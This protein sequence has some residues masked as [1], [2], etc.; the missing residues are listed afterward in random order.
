MAEIQLPVKF[1]DD[2]I[3]VKLAREL[4]MGIHSLDTILQNNQ[5]D[6][7]NWE[8]IQKHPRFLQ[9]L[10]VESSTW[11]SALNTHER[12]KLK[13]AAMIEEWL[14]EL[15][16]RMHDSNEALN[17]KIEAGKLVRDL[18][19]FAKGAVGFEGGGERFSV[20]IN[21]GA[22]N[23]IKIEKDVTPKVIEAE[24]R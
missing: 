11:G 8:S 22:D 13:S 12:V 21:L 4:A 9:L 1:D 2:V 3:F 5:I 20:T 18:A 23:Q 14:P 10:E 19:G 6:Q 24:D 16:V 15:F 7:N 17:S